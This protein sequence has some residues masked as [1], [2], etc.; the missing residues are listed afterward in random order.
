MEDVIIDDSSLEE[1]SLDQR[2]MVQALHKGHT[3][4]LVKNAMLEERKCFMLLPPK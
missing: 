4:E 2:S 1:I 3:Y